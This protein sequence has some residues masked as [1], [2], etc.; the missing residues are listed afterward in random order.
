M[1]ELIET[2]LTE[3]KTSMQGP[4]AVDQ[5]EQLDTGGEDMLH[6]SDGDEEEV[7]VLQ[8]GHTQASRITHR[9]YSHQDCF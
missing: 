6:F 4:V 5:E 2:K 1:E 3:L 8:A 9:T 7:L